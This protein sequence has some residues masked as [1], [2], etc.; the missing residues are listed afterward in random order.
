MALL[1]CLI[2]ALT[3]EEVEAFFR[4]K[5]REQRL[6]GAVYAVMHNGEMVRSGAYG[7]ANLELGVPVTAET[8]FQVGSV[9]KQFAARA[10]LM[11]AD[12]GKLSLDDPLNWY[13]P[14]AQKVWE[15]ITLRHLLTHTSGIPN[16]VGMEEFSFHTDYTRQAFL[17]LLQDR[18]LEFPPGE[19]FQYSSAA[20]SL[21]SI[22]IEK[23]AGMPYAAFVEERIFKPA[24][25]ASTRINDPA[26]LVEGRA[27]GY[28]IRNG[29]VTNGVNLRPR[30]TA[31]S[32]GVLTTIAD[33]ARYERA[34]RQGQGLSPESNA[35]ILRPVRLNSG[36]LH[37]YGLGWY[38]RDVNRLEAVY[39]TGT[40]AAGFRAAYYRHL[41]TGVSVVFLCNASGDGVEPLPIAEGIA[42]LYIH[43]GMADVSQ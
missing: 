41:P 18:D 1:V 26:S 14:E 2:P 23:T 11:L 10:V 3:A 16:W 36:Q 39:H 33:L 4:A 5:I 38:L 20:Y 25:M 35:G 32:G 15:R 42:H 34:L 29:E 24:G 12:E 43:Q 40:T 7:F 30:I 22:V 37:P 9:S 8:V 27:Q 19:R 21:L 31:P 17:A 6:P 28:V 13:L